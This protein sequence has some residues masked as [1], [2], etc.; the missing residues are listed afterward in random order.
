[1]A[2]QK[3]DDIVAEARKQAK[4]LVERTEQE[5]DKERNNLQDD[6]EKQITDVSLAVAEKILSRKITPED[7]KKLIADCLAKWSKDS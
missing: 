7:D 4:S 2:N 6:I 1:M 5:L 3:A